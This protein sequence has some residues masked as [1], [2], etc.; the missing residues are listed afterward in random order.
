MAKLTKT[1]RWIARIWSLVSLGFVLMFL[2]GYGLDP[3]EA[4]PAG[5]D[6]IVMAFFPFGVLLFMMLGW[7]WE[8]WGGI[9]TIASLA[10]FY[11][12]LYIQKQILA[13]GPYILLVATPGFL[14]LVVWILEKY[15]REKK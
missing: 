5:T 2:I 11:I 10:G 7:K 15:A 1:I 14:F 4:P 6:L 9:G 3:S 13:L 8:K 12:A